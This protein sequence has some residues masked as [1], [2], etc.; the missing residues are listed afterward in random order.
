MFIQ[1]EQTP[2][3]E[4]LKFLPG[5]IVLP[6]GTAQFGSDAEAKDAPLAERLLK[7]DYV[8]QVFYGRDFVSVTKSPEID[9]ETLKARILAEV[10]DHMTAGLPMITDAF[11]DN[12][13]AEDDIEE[14]EIDRQ[15]KALL[16]SHVKPAVARD[17]GNIEFVR[18][19]EDSGTVFLSMQG[20]CAGCPSSTMT[21]KHGIEN[22][23]R[24]YI[25]EVT[26]VQ[27]AE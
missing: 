24:H 16:D 17:G 21:L 10:M 6:E 11:D 14:T 5:Q 23:M 1:T 15:I 13:S 25:P 27:P 12:A 19:D 8:E 22:L 9:W 2:N 7:M 3:P 26:N 20:A 4:T 18:F